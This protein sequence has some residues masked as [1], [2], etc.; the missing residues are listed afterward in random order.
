MVSPLSLSLFFQKAIRYGVDAIA[1]AT[2]GNC[3]EHP[4][5][6]ADYKGG[7]RRNE[8]LFE[9]VVSYQAVPGDIDERNK[10]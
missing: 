1:N 3:C 8:R 2:D 10:V 9:K 6:R 4:F 5:A 7:N